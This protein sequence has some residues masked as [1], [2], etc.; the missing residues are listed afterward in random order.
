MKSKEDEIKEIFLA[1][2]QEQ[3]EEELDKLFTELEKNHTGKRAINAIFPD[4]PHTEGKCG[5]HGL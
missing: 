4:Y 2:S 1:E 3:V 5:R